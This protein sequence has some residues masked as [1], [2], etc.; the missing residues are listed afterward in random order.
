M[1]KADKHIVDQIAENP[2]AFFEWLVDEHTEKLYLVIRKIVGNHEDT[3]D[4][5]QNTFIKIWQNLHNF[6]GDSQL[7]SW[8]YRIACNEA[9]Q[10]IRKRKN[11]HSNSELSL[12]QLRSDSYVDHSHTLEKLNMAIEQLPEKQ[13]QVFILRYYQEYSY[14]DM[15]NKLTTSEGALKASYHHAVKKIESFLKED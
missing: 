8:L 9:F 15:A 10:F 6:R 4:V 3:D 13:K 12:Q 7:Y 2:K 14:K 1:E 5:L 11:E